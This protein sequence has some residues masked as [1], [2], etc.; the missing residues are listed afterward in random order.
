MKKLILLL[1]LAP[2]IVFGQTKKNVILIVADDLGYG[3][4][5]RNDTV[6][7]TPII[8][9]LANNGAYFDRFY[10]APGCT[11][12]RAM[13]MT[14]QYA[15]K[16]SMHVSVIL[17]YEERHLP[18][19]FKIL[20]EYL[21]DAG[22]MTGISGKWHLGHAQPEHLPDSR[23]FEWT[24]GV[25]TFGQL[26]YFSYESN[27]NNPGSGGIDLIENGQPD[28]AIGT[29]Q[30]YTNLTGDR[31]VDF[32]QKNAN[33]EQ[34]FFLYLPFLAPH[35][36]DDSS[37]R[38]QIPADSLSIAPSSGYTTLERQY[39]VMLKMLDN[40]IGRIWQQVKE[41]GIEEETIIIFMSDNG[42][43]I[44]FGGNNA[45]LSGEKGQT[46][47]G[48]MRVPLIWYEK[49]AVNPIVIDTNV[50]TF[51][52]LPSILAANGLS[53]PSNVDGENIAPLLRGQSGFPQRTLLAYYI[54]GRQYVLYRGDYKLCN[55]CTA[56][57][58][59]GNPL[60]DNIRMYNTHSDPGEATNIIGA[61]T[62]LRDLMLQALQG[63]TE[64]SSTITGSVEN[65]PPSGWVAPL[66]WGTAIQFSNPNY[67]YKN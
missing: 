26:D 45:V 14:G 61:N 12:T 33:G 16:T 22:Y 55:N 62:V 6:Y 50:A 27:V 41:S 58:T 24:S 11:P 13:L 35:R 38:N 17:R 53:I 25:H 1:L 9:S 63:E 40:E 49:G 4:I 42:G 10:A 37:D 8:D 34:P 19:D 43:D 31:A 18:L 20:P 54:P 57:M 30:Y 23:G 28:Q 3:D 2:L 44:D 59:S 56:Y 46:T 65:N 5:S 36:S 7:S 32:I 21:Q 67:F 15:H 64:L 60:S 52:L 51:D 29:N 39:W 47:D 66:F 48:G